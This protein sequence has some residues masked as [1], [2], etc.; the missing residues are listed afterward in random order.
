MF[1]PTA[2][3]VYVI[4]IAIMLFAFIIA[5]WLVKNRGVEYFSYFSLFWAHLYIL[6][7]PVSNLAQ[8][9]QKTTTKVNLYGFIFFIFFI[10]FFLSQPLSK[11]IN[12]LI[13]TIA[14]LFYVISSYL[15]GALRN[16]KNIIVIQIL[17]GVPKILLSLFFI[18]TDNGFHYVLIIMLLWSVIIMIFFH[19]EMKR[20][21]NLK[22]KDWSFF[23]P[24]V[25]LKLKSLEWQII[26]L[27]LAYSGKMIEHGEFRYA[28]Q[29]VSLTLTLIG[30]FNMI[31]LR[32][33][34][35]KKGVV[36]YF[37][38]WRKK[39]AIYTLLL[40]LTTFCMV[41]V[42]NNL[43]L[44]EA[45]LDLLLV[46]LILIN[47]SAQF[48][49]TGIYVNLLN[50]DKL[51]IQKFVLCYFLYALVFCLL[52]DYMSIILLIL[53]SAVSVVFWNLEIRKKIYY[54]D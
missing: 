37:S 24:L 32:T 27:L 8:R 26:P 33:I 25:T 14:S 5:N 48:G 45:R 52:M 17:E 9:N 23:Y 7:N 34:N 44:T 38:E 41:L 51:F 4:R 20:I 11:N 50:I 36:A 19:Q 29:F 35:I 13:Y 3:V 42:T 53:G 31:K 22:Y 28:F 1:K 6:V 39:L 16:S 49:P 30:V 18:Y 10:L 43:T 21:F 46:I 47:I 40:S 2:T 54:V 12:P 15:L